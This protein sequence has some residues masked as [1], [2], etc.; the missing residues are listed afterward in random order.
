M[1]SVVLVCH[2]VD[3]HWPPQCWS[4]TRDAL[5]NSQAARGTTA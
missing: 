5:I 4:A 3:M 2:S 1:C